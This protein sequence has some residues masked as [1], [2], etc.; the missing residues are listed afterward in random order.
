M[1]SRTSVIFAISISVVLCGS[2]R[3]AHAALYEFTLEGTVNYSLVPR[4]VVGEPFIIRYAADTQDLFPEDPGGGGYLATLPTVVFPESNAQIPFEP[5]D[6]ITLRVALY[7]A[8]VDIVSYQ[9]RGVLGP[10]WNLTI[11]F[12]FPDG[13]LNSDAL[14][15]TLPLELGR[16]NV[17]MAPALLDHIRGDITSYSSVAIP[18]PSM[19]CAILLVTGSLTSRRGSR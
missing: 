6:E 16:S 5:S 12:V 2:A 7:G 3:G 4:P 17:F 10:S 11:G 13:T 1:L 19:T 9:S 15:L 8:G 14:P 18:E